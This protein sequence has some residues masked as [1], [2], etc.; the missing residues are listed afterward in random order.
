M[1]FFG[2]SKVDVAIGELLSSRASN[3]ARSYRGILN[4]FQKSLG[5]IRLVQAQ[6]INALRFVNEV[7]ARDVS[8]A[9]LYR[10]CVI[11][12]AIYQY[13]ERNKLIS[14]NPF[15]RI[16]ESLPNAPTGMIRPHGLLTLDEIGKLLSAPS[17]FTAEGKRDRCIF[18]LLLG[19]ALR[20]SELISLNV[21]S[22]IQHRSGALEIRLSTTKAG[23]PQKVVPS[24]QLSSM[25]LSY[26]EQRRK[27]FA[28]DD[29]PLIVAYA[30]DFRPLARLSVST[31]RRTIKGY[32]RLVGVSSKMTV[33][34]L[35]ATAITQLLASGNSYRE[36]QE[37]SRHSSIAMVEKYDKRRWSID[38]APGRKLKY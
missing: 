6:E 26:L 12:S 5:S 8:P 33:H 38:N 31:L 9:T 28:T 29:Q 35:R 36:V 18:A 21:G 15:Q 27:E 1:W 16:I 3:S 30:C 4:E 32:Y 37:F 34:S 10:K 24:D 11:L 13:L 25:I 22:I 19:G 14:S 20:I 17:K 23:G 2:S 7:K